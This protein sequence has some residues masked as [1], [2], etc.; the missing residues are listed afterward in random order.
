MIVETNNIFTIGVHTGSIYACVLTTAGK[1]Y[2][3]GKAA[4]TG[5]GERNDI[6]WPTLIEHA[7]KDE[8]V[9]QI[10]VATEGFHTM[11]LT[12]SNKLFA[13]GHNRVGQLGIPSDDFMQRNDDGGYYQPIPREI[14]NIPTLPI[15]QVSIMHPPL[16]S[17]AC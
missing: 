2:S 11:A 10:A 16:S 14:L 1:I 9:V 6:L 12:K 4:F 7:L 5:H 17:I 3:F 13:W 15:K 8:F